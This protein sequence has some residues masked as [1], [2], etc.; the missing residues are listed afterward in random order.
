VAAIAAQAG[1]VG[2]AIVSDFHDSEAIMST[3]FAGMAAAPVSRIG[4]VG[5]GRMGRPM[6][7][8]AAAGGFQVTGWDVDETAMANA[9]AAGCMP[10]GS[11]GECAQNS[12]AI[13]VIVPTDADFTA[14]CLQEDG[15]FQSARAGTIICAS[16]SLL[17]ETASAMAGQAAGIGLEFLDMPLTKGVRAAVTGTMTI[18]VGGKAEILDR[19]RPVLETFSEAIHLVGGA[20]AGQVAKSVNNILLW[21]GLESAVEALSLGRAY[22]LEAETL[23]QALLDCSAESWVLRQ[24]RL[25]Q[26]TW[27]AKDLENVA[28]M[29]DAVHIDMPLVDRLR[30][31]A[32]DINQRERIT[33]LFRNR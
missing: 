10:A 30:E 15:I 7:G 8:H 4:F 26:P 29:A 2:T 17:P 32:G 6:A 11:L 13:F 18:L 1:F 3:G 14:A 23:R 33:A 5:L 16:S 20:G 21:S 12:D 24:L 9:K 31:L 28:L 27:P 25:I 19:L 22:G